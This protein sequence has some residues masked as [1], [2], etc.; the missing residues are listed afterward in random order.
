MLKSQWKHQIQQASYMAEIHDLYTEMLKMR[1]RS[2]MQASLSTKM[3]RL[4][5]PSLTVKVEPENVLNTAC[6]GRSPSWILASELMTPVKP[7]TGGIQSLRGPP[8]QYGP[9][10]VTQQTSRQ[11][12]LPVPLQAA[13][14]SQP[15][16]PTESSTSTSGRCIGGRLVRPSQ[17]EEESPSTACN[18][19][20]VSISI[21]GGVQLGSVAQPPSFG[22]PPGI[23]Q[24]PSAPLP[25]PPP[26]ALVS[27][28][29]IAET[30]PQGMETLRREAQDPI[31]SF[32]N[33]GAGSEGD[34]T[35]NLG[36][37]AASERGGPG[38]CSFSGFVE[39]C[40]VVSFLCDVHT[41]SRKG[42][43]C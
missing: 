17:R 12:D 6:P 31:R 3:C 36:G 37:C 43:G 9:S 10:P 20:T 35:A 34:G 39:I 21:Q 23:V 22:K 42:L 33:C 29:Q 2:D 24:E 16:E 28:S 7:T 13:R 5:Q 41:F 18:S 40:L 38:G 14:I 8:V 25:P 26:R 15:A 4:E 27:T 11:H 19:S 1:E 32:N 30:Y